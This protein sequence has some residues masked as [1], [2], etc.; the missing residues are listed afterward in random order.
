MCDVHRAFNST[1]VPG[2]PIANRVPV[3]VEVVGSHVHRRLFLTRAKA[4]EQEL[5]KCD[6]K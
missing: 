2:G 4:H 5:A 6:E 3:E 1:G